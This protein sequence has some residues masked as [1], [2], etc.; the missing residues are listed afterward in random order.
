MVPRLEQCLASHSLAMTLRRVPSASTASSPG[1]CS[2]SGADPR[3]VATWSVTTL[4]TW[5]GPRLETRTVRP[6]T[7]SASHNGGKD[8]Q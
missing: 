2:V 3:R 5:D 7:A 1:E 4:E 6:R 8:S